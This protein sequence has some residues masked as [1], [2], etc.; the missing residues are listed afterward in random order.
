MTLAAPSS[1]FDA[2][3]G[4]LADVAILLPAF[5]GQA[6]VERSLASFREN[7]P[8]YALIVD[9][10]SAP[11][12]VAPVIPGMSVEILRIPQNGG[13]EQARKTGIDA[14][15][16]RGYR[17]AACI[18]AGDLAAPLRLQ[19]QHAAMQAS[20]ALAALGMWTQVVDR[21]GQPLF[22]LTPATDAHTLRR[23]R[24]LRS[25][26][27]NPSVMLRIDAVLAV[28]NYRAEY[29]AAEDLDMFL[30]LMEH[31]DCANLPELGL[32]YELN[33]SGVS[34]T[35]RRR[36]I[37]ST[38]RLLGKYFNAPNPY[39]WLGLV[40]NLLHLALP[41]RV[42]HRV[43]R[44]LLSAPANAPDGSAASS[45]RIALVC[46]M[47]WAMYTYR[48]GL[49]RALIRAGAQVTIIAPRDDTSDALAAMGC[50]CI[51]L[52]LSA[53][54]TNPVHDLRTLGALY[55]H[56]RALRPHVV[57]HYT[58]K[59]NIYGSIASW[60]ARVP[61]VAVTTGLGYVFIQQSRTAQVAKK[62]YRFAFRFP[63]E[64]WFLNR[65]DEAAFVDQHLLAHPE[66][67]RLL[68]G[69]GIDLDQYP[70][71]PL[72][73]H[74]DDA[75]T[76]LLIGRM[77]WDK[78]VGEYVEAARQLRA[79]YPHARF[80]LLGPTGVH[81]PEAIL[82]EEVR[83]W[84]S[85]GVIEYLDQTQDVR[86]FIA[87]ADCVVLPSYREGVP[88]TLMEACAMGRPVVATDVPGCRDVI[89]HGENG[90][91]CDA[92]NAA[93]LAQALAQMLQMDALARC[94]MGVRGRQKMAQEFDERHVIQRYR[95]EVH[96][97]TGI[98]F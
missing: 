88:R 5:N 98:L 95:E 23:T 18:D 2:R 92:R 1:S 20:P 94:A 63:R 51:D 32:Y 75:F 70:Y 49:L 57:F 91:L 29:P 21:A 72:P 9:D 73:T 31:Y 25:P 67:A 77:L 6:D 80:C 28:G 55:R 12:L 27:V 24:F 35:K 36:Q 97:I 40:K 48:Q 44:M 84:E 53:K 22:M 86:P 7:A 78:G 30:R 69:E 46:N 11:P 26:I 56:Y 64:V 96:Q 42:L 85:E 8:L 90:L 15:A 10:G 34:A 71:T 93:S 37:I 38:L 45:L 54:G 65:D 3:T 58:I 47:A 19:K 61:S 14:L 33:E 4:A 66:R 74:H 59:P 82:R 79:R 41:W 76:F 16:A 87:G 52:P 89:V 43:K 17:Y 81:N 60:L 68:H 83:A 62:L 13:I 50:R 39:D